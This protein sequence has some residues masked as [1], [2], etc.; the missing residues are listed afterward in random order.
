VNASVVDS[1][2][3]NL[4]DAGNPYLV[5]SNADGSL[6]PGEVWTIH[7]RRVV[8]AG[9][10]DPLPNT[11]TVSAVVA[12]VPSAGFDGGN[13]ITP[14]ASSVLS[15]TVDLFKPGVDVQKTIVGNPTTVPVGTTITFHFTITNTSD[16]DLTTPALD[17][18]NGNTPD[19]IF[20]SISDPFLG[21]LT[22]NVIAAG[23]N[24]LDFSETG[25]FDVN[26]TVQA[27]DAPSL[28]NTVTVHYHPDGFPNDV[29]DSASVTL[30]VQTGGRIAPTGTTTQQFIDFAFNGTAGDPGDDGDFADGG[31]NYTASGG[32]ITNVSGPGAAFYFTFFT[33]P[34]NNFNVQVVQDAV[35]L[36]PQYEMDLTTLQVLEV[37]GSPPNATGNVL[38]GNIDIPDATDPL[39]NLN[40]ASLGGI[41]LTGKLLVLRW[42]IDPKSIQ[43]EAD[44]G[45]TYTLNFSTEVNGLQV[46]QDPDGILVIDSNPLHL[47]GPAAANPTGEQLTPEALKSAI[48]EAIASWRAAGISPE[49]L[50]GLR[51][52][53]FSIDNLSNNVLG[54]QFGNEIVI[55][56]DAA[57]YGYS[58]GRVNLLSVV[59]HELGH[60]LGFDHDVLGENLALGPGA[61]PPSG[62]PASTSPLVSSASPTSSAPVSLDVGLAL[63]SPSPAV[64]ARSS[65]QGSDIAMVIGATRAEIA[66]PPPLAF[67]SSMRTDLPALAPSQGVTVLTSQQGVGERLAPHAGHPAPT[68]PALDLLFSGDG[69]TFVEEATHPPVEQ[70][71]APPQWVIDRLFGGDEAPLSDELID[72]LFGADVAPRIGETLDPGSAGIGAAVALVGVG[73]LLGH[74]QSRRVPWRTSRA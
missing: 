13:V 62:S 63:R 22:A 73:H 3:G 48:D 26:Y 33:A 34:S 44:P 40:G 27:K 64:V 2:L 51:Q 43:G 31:F 53:N 29:K 58:T 70:V 30:P 61:L 19:L 49:V 7:A 20:D 24:V 39:V 6:S 18:P 32:K 36:G 14:D 56:S 10:A 16:G 9:D 21:D 69:V 52:L 37:V 15:H 47:A 35:G 42:R 45:V 59:K 71:S 5:S 57:G 46:D 11:V 8:Q 68:T 1:L 28:T 67:L 74:R 50:N 25:S 38:A 54:F 65:A 41:N 23:L 72:H 60:A 66:S 17:D 4:L 12:A 55:D